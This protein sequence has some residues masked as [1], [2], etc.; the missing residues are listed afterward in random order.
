M[1]KQFGFCISIITAILFFVSCGQKQKSALFTKLRSNESGIRF[2][3][4]IHD[5]DTSYSFINEFGYMGG[6]VGIGDFN[7]DGLKDI[8]FSGNQVSSRLYINRGNNK[9][10]DIT[11][12]AGVGTN[13]W[14]TGVSIADVNSDGYD[15]IYVCV[16]GKDLV[17]REK[18]LLFINQHDLTFREQSEEYGLA[19]TG[20]STQAVFF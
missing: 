3:N 19:N 11:E 10:D 6:G 2:S 1:K 14:A 12:E 5:K 16:F 4:D 7:N 9:F 20:Y 8:Y 15:D 18:N 17:R 13:V